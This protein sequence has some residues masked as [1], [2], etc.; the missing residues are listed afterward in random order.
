VA[1]LVDRTPDRER[2]LAMG[3]LSAS[4]DV[5]VVVGS[6]LVGAV[7]ERASF[8]TGFGVGAA[9][10]CAAVAVFVALEHRLNRGPAY[11]RSATEV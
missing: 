11:P 1:L 8:G 3:T 10:A 6:A 5:G 2:G 7:I 9:G 4:W